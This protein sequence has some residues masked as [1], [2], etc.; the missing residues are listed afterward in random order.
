L[1]AEVPAPANIFTAQELTMRRAGY[2]VV[3]IALS[4]TKE[5]IDKY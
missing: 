5:L 1:W 2:T 3:V 4:F